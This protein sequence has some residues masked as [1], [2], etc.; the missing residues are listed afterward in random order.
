MQ[1][2][3]G[4]MGIADFQL[5]EKL[6]RARGGKPKLDPVGECIHCHYPL[7]RKLGFW[8]CTNDGCCHMFWRIPSSSANEIH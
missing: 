7:E 1:K 4:R 6:E 5:D 8:C 3:V 2:K